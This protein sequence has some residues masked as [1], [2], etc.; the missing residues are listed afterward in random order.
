MATHTPCGLGLTS[1][2]V[3]GGCPLDTPFEGI[4]GSGELAHG[5]TSKEVRVGSKGYNC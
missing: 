4:K 2:E 1:K 5:L 3:R